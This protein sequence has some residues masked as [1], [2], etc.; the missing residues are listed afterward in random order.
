M[1]LSASV[2]LSAGSAGGRLSLH[3]ASIAAAADPQLC[4]AGVGGGVVGVANDLVSSAPGTAR[5]LFESVLTSDAADG[6]AKNCAAAGIAV[7]DTA[8]AKP[9]TGLTAVLSGWDAFFAIW[10]DPLWGLIVPFLAILAVLLLVSR[11]LPRLVVAPDT[12]GLRDWQPLTRFGRAARHFLVGVGSL[13]VAAFLLTVGTAWD[14]LPGAEP[15]LEWLLRVSVLLA[16]AAAATATHMFIGSADPHPPPDVL[17]RVGRLVVT[18]ILGVLAIWL[19]WVLLPVPTADHSL[20][21]LILALATGL[22]GLGTVIVARGNGLQIGMVIEGRGTDGKTDTA[23]AQRVQAK[24]Y[25]MTRTQ[26]GQAGIL[27]PQATDATIPDDALSLVPDGTAAKAATA[28]LRALWPRS[29]WR[30][31]VDDLGDGSVHV[32]MYRN[33]RY[34]DA[35]TIRRPDF[36]LS[37][38]SPDAGKAAAAV[39]SK[40]DGAKAAPADVWTGVAAFVLV[41]LAA[42]Y[43]YLDDGLY[44][45]R[46]WRSV[47]A[48]TCAV[49]GTVA[50]AERQRLLREAIAFDG[51][52]IAA[53]IAE[54]NENYGK[55]A[56]TCG[57][58]SAGLETI[59]HRFKG[60]VVKQRI[61]SV[62]SIEGN[63]MVL[64]MQFNL[65]VSYCNLALSENPRIGKL[66]AG[67]KAKEA[68]RHWNKA[69]GYLQPVLDAVVAGSESG[70]NQNAFEATMRGPALAL[71]CLTSLSKVPPAVDHSP[72]MNRRRPNLPEKM[73]RPWIGRPADVGL[74]IEQF[75]DLSRTALPTPLFRYQRACLYAYLGRFARAEPDLRAIAGNPDLKKWARSDPSFKKWLQDAEHGQVAR[76][77]LLSPPTKTILD[78]APFSQHRDQLRARGITT[79]AGLC[80]FGPAAARELGLGDLE[81]RHWQ[82]VADLQSQLV[83]GDLDRHD[84]AML[85]SVL[86][87]ENICSAE[88]LRGAIADRDPE[89]T[90]AAR[91]AQRA[92]EYRWEPPDQKQFQAWIA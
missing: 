89:T 42:R 4:P 88:Q 35:A 36:G 92:A 67:A 24:L 85:L 54:L 46:D 8:P 13:V 29:A 56:D 1:L 86:L 32:T 12:I 44:R 79:T 19:A 65:A 6:V 66:A 27:I 23:A 53:E 87:S 34:A 82:R 74:F 58:L 20:V 84:N 16:I 62:E 26:P 11:L 90:I 31:T 55:S 76:T 43:P 25:E 80:R 68:A 70:R 39:S 10:I 81:S 15:T 30:I 77:E 14:G 57:L 37:D 71:W 63:Q 72:A 9:Q 3:P 51:H 49:G 21:W 22:A 64:R 41:T 61:E 47:A 91:V 69:V 60:R 7:L 78:V 50:D 73:L 83:T 59:L 75:R 38:S 45:V 28:V 52:N 33:K 5:E 48:Y 17:E 40:D 18:A 2:G